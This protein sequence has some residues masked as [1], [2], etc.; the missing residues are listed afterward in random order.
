MI[1]QTST[2]RLQ[3]GYSILFLA[4]PFFAMATGD[5]FQ[6]DTNDL[7]APAPID[8][9]LLLV[10]LLGVYFAYRFLQNKTKQLYN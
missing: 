8:N 9:Y 5:T 3:K 10:I 1:P 7:A 4:L 2:S 6:D